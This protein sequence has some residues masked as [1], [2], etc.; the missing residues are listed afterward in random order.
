MNKEW[1]KEKILPYI[2][3]VVVFL[4]LSFIYAMPQLMEGKVLQA[5]DQMSAAGMSQETRVY[6]ESGHS[7]FWTGAMFGG[8]PTF[9]TG[10]NEYPSPAVDLNYWRI[11]RLFAPGVMEF[12]LGYFLGFFIFLRA[13]KVNRYLSI[14]GSIALTLST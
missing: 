8:M 11:T 4:T 12:F 9:Q 7:T 10:G 6:N 3:A 1:F 14:V 13:F 2:I 5:S